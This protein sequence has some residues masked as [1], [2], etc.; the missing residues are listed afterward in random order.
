MMQELQE[1]WVELRQTVWFYNE[2]NVCD[3]PTDKQKMPVIL[4][5]QIFLAMPSKEP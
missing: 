5:D 3:G 2:F 1:N 4:K